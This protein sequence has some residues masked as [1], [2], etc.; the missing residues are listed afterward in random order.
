MEVAKDG[1][2]T[3]DFVF[4]YYNSLQLLCKLVCLVET[5]TNKLYVQAN[6]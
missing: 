1:D 2:R 3:G 4:V 6:E 5:V